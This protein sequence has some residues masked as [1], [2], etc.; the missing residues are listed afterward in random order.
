MQLTAPTE[1]VRLGVGEQEGG[2]ARR[3]VGPRQARP[4]SHRR[5]EGRAVQGHRLSGGRRGWDTRIS[6]VGVRTVRCPSVNKI[7]F[8]FQVFN[9]K[10]NR[11]FCALPFRVFRKKN[12][13][14]SVA[15]CLELKIANSVLGKEHFF[16]FTI[17]YRLK[18]RPTT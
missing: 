10:R 18:K 11:L 12:V 6:E 15:R 7:K 3:R 14:I 5:R 1:L 9:K 2:Q 16:Y 8:I 17:F 4:G 13:G